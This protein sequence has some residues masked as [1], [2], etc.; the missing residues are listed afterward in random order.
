MKPGATK[1]FLDANILY[2]RTLRD[3]FCIL[4][5]ESGVDGIALHWSEDVLA[6][7]IYHLRK[8]NPHLSD[9]QVG[10]W[11][12]TLLEDFPN[13]TIATTKLSRDFWTAIP[14]TL[15]SLRLPK[16]VTST[17]LLPTTSRTSLHTLTILSL[18][19]MSLMNSSA[20]SQ[21]ADPT[22]PMQLRKDSFSIG[23]A[24]LLPKTS[25]VR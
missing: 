11:R 1:V 21:S 25:H 17:T 2:S 13:A 7:M 5:Q 18:K 24:D 23:V 3:W 16:K 15:M 22:P 6:E 9:K 8:K 14:L 12:R 10:G 19:S 20:S 4:S